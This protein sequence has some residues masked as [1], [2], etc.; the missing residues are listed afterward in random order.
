MDNSP[1]PGSRSYSTADVERILARAIEIEQANE[2]RITAELLREIAD[3][4]DISVEAMTQALEEARR[5]PKRL[6]SRSLVAHVARWTG[7]GLALG[8]VTSLVRPIARLGS[9][10]AESLL[11][12]AA[13]AVALFLPARRTKGPSAQA[14]YQSASGAVWFGFAAGF[15]LLNTALL[16]DMFLVAGVGAVISALVGG[17][18]VRRGSPNTPVIGPSA[19]DSRSHVPLLTPLSRIG[20]WF[21][22]LLRLEGVELPAIT[23]NGALGTSRTWQ[24]GS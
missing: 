18:L 12:L 17:L 11:A 22:R 16:D 19:S 10:H 20:R 3:E 24:P 7:M 9:F 1:D 6:S 8:L 21:D 23:L 5:V 2:G 4:V 15:M 14:R 13:L